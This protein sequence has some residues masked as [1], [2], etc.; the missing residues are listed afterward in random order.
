MEYK[1]TEKDL[2]GE[3]KDFPIEVV[4]KMIE[5]QVEQGNKPD[6][7]VFQKN[8]CAIKKQNG[9]SWGETIEGETFWSS[10]LYYNSFDVFFQKY[11]KPKQNKN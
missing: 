1:V 3:I 6:V 11:P 4:Q 7:T 2:I 9:F 10:I 8:S 5:R